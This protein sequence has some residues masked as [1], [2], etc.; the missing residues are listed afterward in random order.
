MTVNDVSKY[1]TESKV[2][3]YA[4]DTVLYIS[5]DSY[6]DLLLSLRIEVDNITQWLHANKLTP[7]VSKTKYMIV[8]SKNKL[9][10]LGYVSLKMNNEELERV[11]EMKYLGMMI[12]ENLNFECHLRYVYSNACKK[13]G[14][15]RKTRMCIDTKTC[16]T[17]YKSLV[18]PTIDYCDVVYM[19]GTKG[20]LEKL[21]KVQNIACRLILKADRRES[22][23]AMHKTLKFLKLDKHRD[24]HLANLCH[25][26]IYVEGSKP[27]S[28]YFIRVLEGNRR[29]TRHAN[30]MNMIVPRINSHTGRKAISYRGPYTWNFLDSDSKL[31]EN[32]N[33]FKSA[34]LKWAFEELDNH[35]T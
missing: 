18:L 23:V 34:V 21:Q 4:D 12:D 3:L 29:I 26:N 20:S 28:K 32:F 25:K 11:S 13:L 24:T 15:I 27:L 33:S 7:N 17:L 19:T 9:K 8:A 5:S 22:T 1:L 10:N 31:N 2:N 30:E 35:P 16:I 6:I 14:A